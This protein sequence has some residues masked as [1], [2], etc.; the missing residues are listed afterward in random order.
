MFSLIN[1]QIA[2]LCQSPYTCIKIIVKNLAT[3]MHFPIRLQCK[4]IKLCSCACST[5]WCE[6]PPMA[7]KPF[8]FFCSYNFFINLINNLV[9]YQLI[10]NT[11]NCLSPQS[12]AGRKKKENRSS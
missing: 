12:I 4:E 3:F 1:D 9:I 2:V 8:K 10:R 6:K 11:L 7:I 5:T